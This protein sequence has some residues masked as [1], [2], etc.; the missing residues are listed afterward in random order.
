MSSNEK[1]SKSSLRPAGNCDK[2]INKLL[3]EYLNLYVKINCDL[4]RGKNILL[5]RGIHHNHH[6]HHHHKGTEPNTF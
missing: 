3:V 1:S 4:T 2:E 5:D 6:H